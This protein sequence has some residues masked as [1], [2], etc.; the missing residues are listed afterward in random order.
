[1]VAHCCRLCNYPQWSV[2]IDIQEKGQSYLSWL[3]WQWRQLIAVI[4][5]AVEQGLGGGK[6][7]GVPPPQADRISPIPAIRIK[8]SF[9]NWAIDFSLTNFFKISL[10]K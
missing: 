9:L 6:G 4:R 5:N 3:E 1:M 8:N 10:L 2:H 7:V